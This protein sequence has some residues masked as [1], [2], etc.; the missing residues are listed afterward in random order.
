MGTLNLIYVQ[1][2][3]I[4]III[5]HWFL[6]L[7]EFCTGGPPLKDLHSEIV[8]ITGAASGLGKGLAQRLAQLGC[9]LVL[10]DV[11]ERENESVAKELNDQTNSKR[12]HAMKCDLTN[13]EEIYKCA[14]T[15]LNSLV[16]CRSYSKYSRS[17]KR[18]VMSQ[19]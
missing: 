17:N 11:N 6:N 3:P 4:L 15:V 2:L 13:R 14:K 12:I 8:L 1:L 7:I 10:W 5:K 16:I 18:S 19:W 9:T